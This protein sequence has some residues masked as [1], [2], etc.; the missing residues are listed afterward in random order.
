MGS[1]SASDI[2]DKA[3]T[4]FRVNVLP[5]TEASW[6]TLRSSGERPS[7]LAAIR[8]WRVSGTARASMGPVGR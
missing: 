3:D 5:R 2:S 7:N 1:S 8:A 4:P 6:T